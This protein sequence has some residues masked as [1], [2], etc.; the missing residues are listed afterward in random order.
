MAVTPVLV[1]K[2]GALAGRTVVDLV[3]GPRH[4]I[5][6]CSDESLVAW[7]WN[8]HGS[9]GDGSTTLR[10]SPVAVDMS[11]VLA[12]KTIVDLAIREY[13]SF[14]LCSDG[15]LAAWGSLSAT[16]PLLPNGSSGNIIRSLP[17]V[18]DLGSLLESGETPVSI[19]S[20]DHN[21]LITTSLGRVI[22]HGSNSFGQ[23]GRG[24]SGGSAGL[25]LVDMSGALSR[26]IV[27]Q[28]VPGEVHVTALAYRRQLITEIM[29]DAGAI[30]LA[31]EMKWDVTHPVA[32]IALAVTAVE[33]GAEI[34]I[35]GQLQVS[36]T[37]GTPI[38]L[39][40]GPNRIPIRVTASN[41]DFEHYLLVVRRGIPSSQSALASLVSSLGEMGPAFESGRFHY[42]IDLP[43]EASGIQFTPSAAN[44]ASAILINGTVAGD[45]EASPLIPLVVGETEIQVRVNA[46]DGVRHSVYQITVRRSQAPPAT[47]ASLGVSAGA[48]SP[49]FQPST[50]TY[51]ITVPESTDSIRLLP[52]VSSAG[53]TIKIAGVN[54]SSGIWSGSLPLRYGVNRFTIAVTNIATETIAYVVDVTRASPSAVATLKTLKMG[55]ASLKPGFNKSVT[56]YQAGVASGVK[57]LTV[58]AAATDGKARIHI[59]GKLLKSGR[60]SAVIPFT[61][62]RT[63]I[64]I[65]VTAADGRTR[66]TYTVT[67]KRTSAKE[68]AGGRA[69]YA[70]YGISEEA[71]M[72]YQEWV[73][74]YFPPAE[75]ANPAISGMHA[76]PR[77]DGLPNLV[78]FALGLDGHRASAAELP[79]VTIADGHLVMTYRIFRPTTGCRIIVEAADDPSGPWKEL[80]NSSLLRTA[81]GTVTV[82][83]FDV[84]GDATSD[85]RFI[86]LKVVTR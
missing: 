83:A 69:Q 9:L 11:G 85:S 41:G 33:P 36:G 57:S 80:P 72:T 76:A 23:L 55:K 34:S 45:G 82:S 21:L 70:A 25:G 66:K 31:R 32:S 38:P 64:R 46:P 20:T 50:T 16:I 52:V 60:N 1:Q 24:S 18:V 77:G 30:P 42:S 59:N 58:T 22:A 28:A 8:T 40:P 3:A 62:N 61:A 19:E 56:T 43:F 4:L 2:N 67:A 63:V 47:L 7:G 48:L 68:A 74:K 51:R 13:E 12:G 39:S 65:V 15:T 73:A 75:R 81:D 29:T 27:G 10:T 6:L 79:Q 86:R 5:A 78:K 54:A 14:A 37:P 84:K 49:A 44:P 26:S 53:S 35:G 71:P 17:A